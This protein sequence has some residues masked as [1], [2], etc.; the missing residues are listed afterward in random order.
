MAREPKIIT[1]YTFDNS[2]T[3]L[4]KLFMYLD[5]NKWKYGISQ[6]PR[7]EDYEYHEDMTLDELY[8][9]DI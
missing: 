4:R 9:N 5:E 6:L 1:I 2:D 3:A 7:P 8:E